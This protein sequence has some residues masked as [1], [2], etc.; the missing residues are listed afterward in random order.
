MYIYIHYICILL[1]T[2]ITYLDALCCVSDFQ[3]FGGDSKSLFLLNI[4]FQIFYL[5]CWLNSTSDWMLLR[6]LLVK[7]IK[8]KEPK[9]KVQKWAHFSFC[10]ENTEFWFKVKN[11]SICHTGYKLQAMVFQRPEILPFFFWHFLLH[12]SLLPLT[13]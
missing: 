10:V 11:Q 6:I 13:I 1:H 8:N 12:F 2:Y 3:Y 5:K 9:L 4:D 7:H